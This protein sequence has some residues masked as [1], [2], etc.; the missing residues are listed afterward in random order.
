VEVHA[1]LSGDYVHGQSR[2]APLDDPGVLTT[3]AYAALAAPD[4]AARPHLAVLLSQTDGQLGGGAL[5]SAH[6]ALGE[7]SQLRV[8]GGYVRRPYAAASTQWYWLQQGLPVPQAPEARV[9]LPASFPAS[10]RFTLDAR[11]RR[12][13]QNG[14]RLT[15]A[16]GARVFHD[17][18][19]PAADY[20]FAPVHLP[21]FAPPGGRL[22]PNIRLRT[23]ASGQTFYVTAGAR[24]S[25]PEGLTHRLR[26][27]GFAHRAG[28]RAR[29]FNQR[30]RRVP[31][32]WAR[33]A[34]RLSAG[35]RFG[36]EG[37]FTARSAE[38]WPAYCRAAAAGGNAYRTRLPPR[39]RVDLSAT[40]R[41]WND[42]LRARL[43]LRNLLDAPLRSHPAGP[44]RRLAFFVSLEAQL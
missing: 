8:Q 43:A 39:L 40:K 2:D 4:G 1:G 9:A 20:G 12:S 11:L 42:H 22:V 24:A 36:L 19:L 16:G 25:F 41:F 44:I 29:A 7:S 38:H 13:F 26:Y 37:R 10:G 21:A 35:E 5:L 31:R 33:Y 34:A 23:G 17:L 27:R 6:P 14:L 18:T 30:F 3:R 15:L 28:D 32:H